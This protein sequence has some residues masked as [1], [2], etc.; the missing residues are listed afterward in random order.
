MPSVPQTTRV[1]SLILAS[2]ALAACGSDPVPGTAGAGG[3]GPGGAGGAGG[4][5]GPADGGAGAPAAAWR[6]FQAAIAIPKS[7]AMVECSTSSCSAGET[8][9][10]LT[11]ELWVCDLAQPEVITT[12]A[13]GPGGEGTHAC[14]CEAGPCPGGKLCIGVLENCSC[15]PRL[16]TVCVD[17]ACSAA[18][19]CPT[20][21]TCVPSGFLLDQRCMTPRCTRDADC[22][23]APGGLCAAVYHPPAQAGYIGLTV[24]CVYPETRPP[25]PSDCGG[26]LLALTSTPQMPG[27]RSC[28]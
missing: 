9:F 14:G 16:D 2:V 11:R 26:Y 28:P 27:Y 6:Q 20:G 17:R 7:R 4:T 24:E 8:C 18:S 10:H 19:E 1:F 21:Q 15:L 25:N 23:R 22:A 13:A 3:G 12:C 5:A